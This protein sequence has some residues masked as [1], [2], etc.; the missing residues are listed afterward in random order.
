MQIKVAKN[1]LVAKLDILSPELP[2]NYL[3]YLGITS[4][5]IGIV[6]IC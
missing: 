6:Y 1:T 3:N 4:K 5:A 2:G